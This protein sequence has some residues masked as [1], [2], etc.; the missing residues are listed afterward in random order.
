VTLFGCSVFLL[1]ASQGLLGK[2][3][4]PCGDMAMV[5]TAR[6]NAAKCYDQST[7]AMGKPQFTGSK[8]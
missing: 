2:Q 4:S 5:A 7:K 6:E 1:G 3:K 8:V